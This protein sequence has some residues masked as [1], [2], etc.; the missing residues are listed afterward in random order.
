MGVTEVVIMV[1]LVAGAVVG[2]MDHLDLVEDMVEAIA[3]AVDLIL[4]GG[5]KFM[6]LWAHGVCQ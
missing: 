5:I 4:I 2:G 6:F 1:V 3:P